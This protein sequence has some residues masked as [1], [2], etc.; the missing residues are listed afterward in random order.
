MRPGN[1]ADSPPVRRRYRGRC[2][3]GTGSA[4]ECGNGALPEGGR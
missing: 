1:E 4:A 3:G 2:G